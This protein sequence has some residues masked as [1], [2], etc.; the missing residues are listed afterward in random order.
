MVSLDIF[1]L[2]DSMF[3]KTV[4]NQLRMKL[5][6]LG[7]IGAVSISGQEQGSHDIADSV[8]EF[9]VLVIVSLIQRSQENQRHVI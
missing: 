7:I 4:E 6:S 9:M 8:I 1:K 2:L 5:H 3:A